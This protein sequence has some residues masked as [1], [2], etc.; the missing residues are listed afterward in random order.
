MQLPQML[1]HVPGILSPEALQKVDSMLPSLKFIDGRSTATGAAKEV[2]NNLQVS[3]DAHNAHPEL[4]QLIGMSIV[5]N[6]LVQQAGSGILAMAI[7][8]RSSIQ[9]IFTQAPELLW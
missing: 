8:P 5:S 6:P 1:L 3:K 7:H 2:K 9:H 4:Q